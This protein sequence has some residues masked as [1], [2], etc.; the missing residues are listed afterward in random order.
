MS[1]L[2]FSRSPLFRS[3]HFKYQCS[4]TFFLFYS[5]PP[6][7]LPLLKILKCYYS[8][9]DFEKNVLY[10]MLH[11]VLT[12]TLVAGIWKGLIHFILFR[13]YL[14]SPLFQNNTSW[15][16]NSYFHWNAQCDVKKGLLLL[17]LRFLIMD[18]WLIWT[19]LFTSETIWLF[20][21]YDKSSCLKIIKFSFVT[22][23]GIQF[24]LLILYRGDLA[25]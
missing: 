24:P 5:S 18:A 20:T 13:Q 8:Y 10:K 21:D 4:F 12:D 6:S 9:R 7:G 1:S 19:T 15:L 17:L 3:A 23:Q 22:R 25:L 11:Q 16:W 14:T 2:L